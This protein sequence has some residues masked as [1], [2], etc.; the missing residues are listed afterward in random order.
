MHATDPNTSGIDESKR[1]AVMLAYALM[2]VGAGI[3]L[4]YFP[5]YL[6][7]LGYSGPEIGLVLG[8]QPFLR[9][10][11]A[12]AFGWA[13]D[14]WRIR[15]RLLV[16]SAT[17]AVGL[18]IPLLWVESVAAMLIVSAGISLLHGPVIPAIDATVMDHLDELGG[19]YGRLR[20]W[21]SLAFI[22]GAGLSALAVQLASPGIVPSLFLLP[23]AIM[24]LVLRRLPPGQATSQGL[25][26]P[27]WSLI[28]PPLAAFLGA[29]FLVH[30]SSGAWNAFFALHAEGLGL[31]EWI[32][33]AAWG[34]A[35]GGEVALFQWGGRVLAVLPPAR[36][37]VLALLVTVLRWT[38]TA[39]VTTTVP[40]AVLQ[41]GHAFT[42]SAFHLAAM[43]L[44]ARLIPPESSTSGQALYGITGFGLGG[45]LGIVLAGALVGPLGTSDLFHFQAM[46][47]ALG[48]L[49]A[50]L[51]MRLLRN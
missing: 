22:V 6:G 46:L 33:G 10:G 48:L 3:Y 51:L 16:A 40:L 39:V 8:V 50:W 35:V 45:S 42:F 37:I 12:M 5:L 31:P 26:V 9:W 28:T 49:P 41:I 1:R 24:P 30:L 18:F 38:L 11:S 36:L 29:V 20:L 13:A 15:H 25:A 43:M 7:H 23:A 19:D 17:L 2:F 21:G 47:A 32:S 44:I 4:P 27:P 14:R 34:L